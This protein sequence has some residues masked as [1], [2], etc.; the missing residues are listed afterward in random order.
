ML[1][2]A[3]QLLAG[4]GGGSLV[5]GTFFEWGEAWLRGRG[6]GSGSGGGC[7]WSLREW[8]VGGGGLDGNVGVYSVALQWIIA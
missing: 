1:E 3:V 4:R 5:L 8:V 6:G 7:G 2:T